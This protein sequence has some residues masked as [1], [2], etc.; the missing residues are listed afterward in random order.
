MRSHVS[1]VIPAMVS[2]SVLADRAIDCSDRRIARTF[3][4]TDRCRGLGKGA[5]LT[6]GV[7]EIVLD[8]CFGLGPTPS[9]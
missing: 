3:L 8:A 7:G 9:G 2:L 4:P 1:H 5:S 6:V